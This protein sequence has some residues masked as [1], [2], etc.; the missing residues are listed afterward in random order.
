[1]PLK[2]VLASPEYTMTHATQLQIYVKI[3]KI[4]I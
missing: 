4:H 3:E 2:F 1:M